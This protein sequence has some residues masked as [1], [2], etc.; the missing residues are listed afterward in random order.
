MVDACIPGTAP[1]SE[2]LKLATHESVANDK[3][4]ID[5]CVVPKEEDEEREEHEKEEE[6]PI[7]AEDCEE[8]A[9]MRAEDMPT[10]NCS[11]DGIAT[12][13]SHIEELSHTEETSPALDNTSEVPDQ[14]TSHRRKRRGRQWHQTW[15]NEDA[16]RY[17]N[18]QWHPRGSQWQRTVQA[19]RPKD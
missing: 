5:S 15:W 9:N 7:C 1:S 16:W 11:E 19:W 13:L 12:Q 17:G 14:P 6:Q 8:D 10:D 2:L 4:S 3:D 18:E